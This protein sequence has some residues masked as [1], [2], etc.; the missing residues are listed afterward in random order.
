L[1]IYCTPLFSINLSIVSLC[2]ISLTWYSQF[3]TYLLSH[4]FIEVNSHTS[5]FV[6]QRGSDTT[7]LLLYVDDIVLIAS[8]V[9]LLQRII[10]VLQRE[11]AM[12]DLG[13]LHH[14]LGMHVQRCSNGLLSAA[15][16]A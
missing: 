2:H 13:E 6:Y 7:F 4:G 16:Y 14:F 15:G 1:P 9:G 8:S 12:K 3:A 10:L 11:F 5:L